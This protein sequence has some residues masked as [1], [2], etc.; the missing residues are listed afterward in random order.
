ME[1]ESKTNGS[2]RFA[3]KEEQESLLRGMLQQ[4][5][6]DLLTNAGLEVYANLGSMPHNIL[7]VSYGRHKAKDVAELNGHIGGSVMGTS[8]DLSR[9]F[10]DYKIQT[11]INY[12]GG[13]GM[14]VYRHSCRNFVGGEFVTEQ[15]LRN[16]FGNYVSKVVLGNKEF[17]DGVTMED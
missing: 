9:M 13:G 1:N 5:A 3:S 15:Q 12:F 7:S 14:G 2:K 11:E 10:F 4:I 8:Y 16:N 17:F 6:T